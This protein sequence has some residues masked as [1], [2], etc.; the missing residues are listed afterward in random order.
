MSNP[1]IEVPPT[2][3]EVTWQEGEQLARVGRHDGSS[4]EL[5]EQ[6]GRSQR[7]GPTANRDAGLR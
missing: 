2:G 4:H 6:G 1:V 5:V 7:V 3:P